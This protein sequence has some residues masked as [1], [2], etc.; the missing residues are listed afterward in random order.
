MCGVNLMTHNAAKPMIFSPLPPSLDRTGFQA[1][2]TPFTPFTPSFEG[3]FGL[4]PNHC[5]RGVP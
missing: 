3:V 4:Q 5:L 1:A 2:F